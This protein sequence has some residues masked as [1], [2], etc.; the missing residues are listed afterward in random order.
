MP[1]KELMLPST[2]HLSKVSKIFG[3]HITAVAALTNANN[4][5]LKHSFNAKFMSE[6]HNNFMQLNG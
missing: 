5:V 6:I 2:S 3:R 1:D 4:T